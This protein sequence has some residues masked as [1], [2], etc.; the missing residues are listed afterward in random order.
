MVQHN[1]FNIP[2]VPIESEIIRRTLHDFGFPEN[3]P[4]GLVDKTVARLERREFEKCVIRYPKHGLE[5]ILALPKEPIRYNPCARFIKRIRRCY[6]KASIWFLK[7]LHHTLGFI[8]I[9]FLERH[10]KNIIKMDSL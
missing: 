7:A 5:V 3:L 1:R 10:K 8:L 9:R 6:L 4:H 2:S